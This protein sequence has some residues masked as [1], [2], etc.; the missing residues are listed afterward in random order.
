[1][2]LGQSL[3]DGNYDSLTNEINQMS[4]AY[5]KYSKYLTEA[6][7]EEVKR[8]I[9]SRE[10]II[11]EAQAWEQAKKS[12]EKYYNTYVPADDRVGGDNT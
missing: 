12:L 9:E 10:A 11:T 5:Q 4:A 8:T 6:Q 1:M 3:S 7:K 2:Q